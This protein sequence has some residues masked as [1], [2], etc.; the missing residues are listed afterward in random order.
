[1][2]PADWHELAT[3]QDRDRRAR[4]LLGRL[5]STPGLREG[6]IYTFGECRLLTGQV[7]DGF[8]PTGERV[9]AGVAHVLGGARAD[10]LVLTGGLG[11]FPL[12]SLVLAEAMGK[13]PV[14]EPPDA[15]ARGALLFARGTVCLAPPAE[16]P[17]VALPAH[18]VRHGLLDEV[19]VPLPWT[20]PFARPADGPLVLDE[21]ELTVDIGDQRT[22][23]PLPGLLPGP[24]LVGV[25]PGW[26]GSGALVVRPASGSGDAVVAALGSVVA[27][28]R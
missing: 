3:D 5:A 16:L 9:R 20:E 17:P 13:V 24:C 12:A 15:A 28:R 14:V 2:L 23:V 10:V 4:A 25:R 27:S 11:W 26:S 1:L 7:V 21:P 19:T 8:A 18:R 6:P 22:T